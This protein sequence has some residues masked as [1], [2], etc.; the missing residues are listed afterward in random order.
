M[1]SSRAL[2]EKTLW[3]CDELGILPEFVKNA[4]SEDVFE[5]E[6]LPAHCYADQSTKRLRIDTKAAA[7]LSAAQY[8]NSPDAW[9]K[10]QQIQ[11]EF[12]LNKAANI[13]GITPELPAANPHAGIIPDPDEE[14]ESDDEDN[15]LPGSHPVR[16]P[17]EA[18]VAGNYLQQHHD[19][20]E[21]DHLKEAAFKLHSKAAK[22]NVTFDKKTEQFLDRI[23]GFG[24][25]SVKN[26]SQAIVDRAMLFPSGSA[27]RN[28]LEGFAKDFKTSPLSGV[29]RPMLTKLAAKL[30]EFDKKY[31]LDQRYEDGLLR[32]EE[33]FFEFTSKDAEA[34]DSEHVTLADGSAYTVEDLQKLSLESL[35]S[36]LGEKVAN[37]LRTYQILGKTRDFVGRLA[38]MDKQSAVLVKTILS[39][40]GVKAAWV[41][42]PRR[43]DDTL[44]YVLATSGLKDGRPAAEGN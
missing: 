19:S 9:T 33:I 28:D 16:S 37:D 22:M 26:A 42:E 27:E 14:E 18:H 6:E 29:D 5:S 23:L 10:G 15:I 24:A 3:R 2:V 4:A 7:W 32:P 44:M 34:L 38:S 12:E 11:I 20:L 25:C 1:T 35:E 8:K 36:V 21:P 13:H 17:E 30:R 40:N 41:D 43:L 31:E 39:K